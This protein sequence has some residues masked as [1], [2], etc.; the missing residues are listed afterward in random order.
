[1]NTWLRRCVCVTMA[2]LSSFA[3]A[4]D[5][6]VKTVRVY[7]VGNSVTDTINYD[8]LA[9]LAASRG[10]KYEWGRHMIPGAPLSWIVN[11][12]WAGMDEGFR[13]KPYGNVKNA[14]ENH[15][16]D[17]I[18]LQPFDRKLVSTNKDGVAEGDLAMIQKIIEPAIAKNADVQVYVYSRWPRMTMSGKSV[19]YDKDAYRDDEPG[20]S[21]DLAKLDDWSDLWARSFDTKTQAGAVESR[22]YFEAVVEGVRQANPKMNKP[23]LMVPVGDVMDALHRK[24]KAGQVPGYTSIWQLYKDGIHLNAQGSYLVGCTYFA[25]LHKQSP[26]GLPTEPY[27][28]TDPSLAKVIQ[29]TIWEVVKEHALTGIK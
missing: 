10:I 11:R 21:F 13:S 15:A 28:L 16:W 29:E 20:E 1:M 19:K 9:A 14:V 17:I 23:V 7:F 12:T 8:G 22:A 25:T 26:V 24:M 4:D 27:K 18:S 2:V 5:E 6:Q 3:H